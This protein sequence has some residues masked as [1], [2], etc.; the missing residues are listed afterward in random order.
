MVGR[1]TKLGFDTLIALYIFGLDLE[2]APESINV[3]LGVVHPR[4]LHEVVSHCRMCTV[5]ANHEV[6]VDFNL[7]RAVRSSIQFTD[8]EPSFSSFEVGTGQFMVE[9]EFDIRHVV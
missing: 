7:R 9:E 2:L 4:K 5:C 1:D 8:L 3:F 6:E